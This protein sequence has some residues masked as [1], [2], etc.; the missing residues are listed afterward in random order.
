MDELEKK[1]RI[2]IGIFLF[3]LIALLFYYLCFVHKSRTQYEDYCSQINELLKNEEFFVASAWANPLELKDQDFEVIK[4]IEFPH[5]NKHYRILGISKDESA[6]IYFALGG[7]AD[8]NWG[9]VFVNDP[10]IN[11]C[12]DSVEW[13]KGEKYHLIDTS[14]NK[15]YQGDK[16]LGKYLSGVQQL[17]RLS[18]N[19]YYYSTM[20]PR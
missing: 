13:I 20:A 8:D 12:F 11:R 15:D 17:E 5:F 14:Q 1:R 3:L 19:A 2:L 18:E 7:A 4:T 10:D 16:A 6:N 9:I